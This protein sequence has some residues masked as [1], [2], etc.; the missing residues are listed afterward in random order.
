MKF[1]Y[2][3]TAILYLFLV[4]TSCS[5]FKKKDELKTSIT[6]EVS[7][8]ETDSENTNTELETVNKSSEQTLSTDDYDISVTDGAI[9][10]NPDGSVNAQGK[11]IKARSRKKNESNKQDSTNT[12]INQNNAKKTDIKE[13]SKAKSKSLEKHKEVKKDSSI[14]G[15]VGAAIFVLIIFVGVMIYKRSK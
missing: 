10:L 12:K 3:L 8:E 15:W 5:I 11:N 1:V 2:K 6:T 4:L 9:N 14:K 13:K 7:Y